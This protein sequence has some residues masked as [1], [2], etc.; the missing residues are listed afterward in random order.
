[1]NKTES[2]E[3]AYLLKLK[4]AV[5]LARGLYRDAALRHKSAA[6]WRDEM[7]WTKEAAETKLFEAVNLWAAGN[8]FVP[9]EPEAPVSAESAP[10]VADSNQA[11]A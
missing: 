5:A 7:K 9:A 4:T 11:I 8:L 1:M 6:E 10:R 2:D 3:L